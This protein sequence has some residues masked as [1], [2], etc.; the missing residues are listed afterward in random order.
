MSIIPEA[1]LD[2]EGFADILG[3][4]FCCI[5]TLLHIILIN[6]IGT[7]MLI[8][9]STFEKYKCRVIAW[10]VSTVD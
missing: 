5:S 7:G 8:G 10:S 1:I 3:D 6:T 9:S 2:M 4:P